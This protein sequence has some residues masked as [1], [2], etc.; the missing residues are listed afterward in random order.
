M[1]FKTFVILTCILGSVYV[2]G[3]H[4]DQEDFNKS[5][6]AAIK[7]AGSISIIN[8]PLL[9]IGQGPFPTIIQE[10]VKLVTKL[11]INISTGNKNSYDLTKICPL[12]DILRIKAVPFHQVPFLGQPVAAVLRQLEAGID[13]QKV[14]LPPSGEC[15]AKAIAAY[16]AISY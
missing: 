15:I 6:D 11:T 7:A 8:G 12:V 13:S 1:S 5:C 2:Q 10:I 14:K 4:P 16:D 9:L 3:A